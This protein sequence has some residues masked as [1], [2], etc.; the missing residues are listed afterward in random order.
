M[1]PERFLDRLARIVPPDRLAEVVE[2]FGPPR[3]VGFRLNPLRAD[4][5]D[6]L[7][8]L[9]RDGLA[10]LPVAWY[11]DA[12]TVAADERPALV[13]SPAYAAGAVYLQNLSSMVPP[14]ALAPEPDD[15]V[16]DLAAAPGSKTTQLAALLGPDADLAAV[17]VVRDRF[18]RLRANLDA[19]GASFVK[20]FLQDGTKVPRYR[21]EH[22]DRVLL[23]A[24]CS[25]EGRFRADEPET[26]A[27]WSE[28]KIREM[29]RRQTALLA[30]AVDSLAVG[31]TLVYATCSFAPEENEA[32]LDRTLTRFG[33][34]LR[35]EPIPLDVPAAQPALPAWDGQA[36]AH[37][38]SHAR[39]LLPDGTY[40]AFFVARLHKTASTVAERP[41]H[42][43]RA[44]RP[45]RR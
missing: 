38:L 22:F 4:P 13:A 26:F 25:T 36:F 11:A 20:T 17:E 30:A 24:P 43:A 44:A 19:A 31:G 7:G 34:A 27:Y 41:R 15:R 1:L 28:R 10:P 35:L 33:D 42:A 18:F 40:E 5:A 14:L 21:P 45:R 8:A 2:T 29:Q 39:R 6:T 23:D 32:V 16:L 37:D 9:C 12:F 3:R